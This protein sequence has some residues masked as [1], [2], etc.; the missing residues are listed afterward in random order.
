MEL[1]VKSFIGATMKKFNVKVQVR[2]VVLTL[3][4]FSLLVS[5]TATYAV[6]S[7]IASTSSPSTT[8]AVNLTALPTAA[9]PTS[10]KL[11][12]VTNDPYTPTTQIPDYFGNPDPISGY[13]TGNFANSPLPVSVVIQGD[14][15]GAFFTAEYNGAGQITKFN[16]VNG[17]VGYNAS[18]TKVSVIGGG[19]YGAT[20]TANVNSADGSI[21]SI[22]PVNHGS[23]YGSTPGIRKF[24]QD[25]PDAI[26]TADRT[27]VNA[28][29]TP[30]TPSYV[31]AS[32]YYEIA[33][34][35]SQ[36]QFSP[37]LPLTTVNLYVQV[38]PDH[39]GPAGA[40]PG[41]CG[42]NIAGHK[43]IPLY[44][45]S[46][47]GSGAPST[48]PILNLAGQQVCGVQT[49]FTNP[50]TPF[51]YLGTTINATKDRPVRVTYDNYLPTG[52]GTCTTNTG[53]NTNPT[54]NKCGGDLILAC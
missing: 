54:V 7:R 28:Q 37:D 20:G 26:P 30:G 33:M 25:L 14:G 27:P 21:T 45:P 6:S 50:A 36:W 23:G 40:N 44:Y 48:T 29:G 4:S 46:T 41:N 38:D 13:A 12:G 9:T 16:A 17:G 24:V 5:Q 35:R 52:S 2:T 11:M 3:L 22:T 19:G 51:N 1:R 18:T 42:T 39:F 31:P 47:R 43:S 15:S 53:V 32:D 34:I 10:A 49:N 8:S